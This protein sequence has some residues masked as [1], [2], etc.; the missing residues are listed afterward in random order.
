[1]RKVSNYFLRK[2]ALSYIF[3]S[4]VDNHHSHIKYRCK[5]VQNLEQPGGFDHLKDY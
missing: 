4:K 3:N 2:V 5:F 1:M